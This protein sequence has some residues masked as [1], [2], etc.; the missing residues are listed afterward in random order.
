[1]IVHVV[2]VIVA[3]VT[4][5]AC[6]IVIVLFTTSC[7]GET[8]YFVS[9]L[10][11]TFIRKSSE[12]SILLIIKMMY[13]NSENAIR[14]DFYEENER[15]LKERLTAL[16]TNT[17]NNDDSLSTMCLSNSGPKPD[18][19]KVKSELEAFSKEKMLLETDSDE[20][21]DRQSLYFDAN[22]LSIRP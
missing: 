21:D 13:C 11:W 15:N 1:M 3:Q 6:F 20:H 10:I 2:F 14:E 8:I 9:T 22:K 5:T 19:Q 12:I 18:R 7:E 4:D 16:T 17:V